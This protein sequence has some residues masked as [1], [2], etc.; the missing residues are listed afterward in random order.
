M[1]TADDVSTSKVRLI[2]HEFVF[3]FFSQVEKSVV[4]GEYGTIEECL[5]GLVEAVAQSDKE[6]A[7]EYAVWRVLESLREKLKWSVSLRSGFGGS[8]A[9]GE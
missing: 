3:N 4:A 2:E 1:A 6:N 5:K 7:A 9:D 8:G